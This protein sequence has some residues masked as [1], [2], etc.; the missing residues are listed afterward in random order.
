VVGG[1]Y[2]AVVNV[3]RLL[4]AHD[5][6]WKQRALVLEEWRAVLRRSERTVAQRERHKGARAADLLQASGGLNARQRE[7]ARRHGLAPVSGARRRAQR[8]VVLAWLHHRRRVEEAE[9][10]WAPMLA[11]DDNAVRQTVAALADTTQRL[12]RTWDKDAPLAT[13]RTIRQLRTLA[14]PPL[15][16][17]AN[18]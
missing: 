4:Q 10:R 5:K 1:W 8:H 15:T 18:R 9:Q 11:S 12:L 16:S 3:D 13:G 7:W 14:R 2:G 6:L 17:K